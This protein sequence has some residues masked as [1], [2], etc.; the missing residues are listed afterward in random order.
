MSIIDETL[1]LLNPARN[2]NKK[3]QNEI[4]KL[5]IKKY[6][7]NQLNSTPKNKSINWKKYHFEIM[8]QHLLK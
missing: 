5:H 7:K 2:G 6:G 1:A 3:A 4:V 8:V